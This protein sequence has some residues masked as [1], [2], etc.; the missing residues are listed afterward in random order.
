MAESRYLDKAQLAEL[1][2]L[3]LFRL[4]PSTGDPWDMAWRAAKLASDVRAMGIN[5]ELFA[6]CWECYRMAL[7]CEQLLEARN[8]TSSRYGSGTAADRI[9]GYLSWMSG[10]VLDVTD[11]IPS[12][13]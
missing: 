12:S 4:E 7:D 10:R 3:D 5:L 11:K 8:L 1:H 13:Q 2:K 9:A 6:I